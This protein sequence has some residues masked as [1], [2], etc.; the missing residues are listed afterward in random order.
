[1]D[2]FPSVVQAVAADNYKVYVYFI[3]GAIRCVDMKPTI[4]KGGVF[5]P[6]QDEK[7]FRN[8]LTVMNDTVAWDLSGKHDPGDCIDIDPCTIY[9]SPPSREPSF[10]I[11]E[12]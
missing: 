10:M 11:P 4:D 3:D 8:T 9:K 5:T 12:N 2:Y 1:M 7:V 6:L